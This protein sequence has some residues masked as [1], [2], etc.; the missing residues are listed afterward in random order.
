MLA[1]IDHG[2]PDVC[3]PWNASRGLAGYGQVN[4]KHAD[5]IWRPMQAHRLAFMRANPTVE[6][7]DLCVCHRC[8]NPPCCNP[9]HLFLGTHADN[10]H[11]MH[12]KGRNR[13]PRGAD[14]W[15]AKL[16]EEQVI[17]ARRRYIAGETTAG[18]AAVFGVKQHTMTDAIAGH[19][20]RHMGGGVPLRWARAKLSHLQI[21][22]VRQSDE[23]VAVLADRYGVHRQIIRDIQ[24]GKR[25]KLIVSVSK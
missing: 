20:W 17:E 4:V 14:K 10:I 19:H 3:W 2:D 12:A 9:H 6:I 13:Q 5:G 25:F 21:I 11:D 8:D 23:P 22:E 1:K 16:T 15:S 18:L 24:S 7:G